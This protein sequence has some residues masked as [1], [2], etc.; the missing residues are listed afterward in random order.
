[1]TIRFPWEYVEGLSSDAYKCFKMKECEQE[2]TS[3]TKS[4][5]VP[6]PI[7]RIKTSYF[8]FKSKRPSSNL[9]YMCRYISFKKNGVNA[10]PS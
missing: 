6:F 3:K 7:S 2:V 4:G 9:F 8:N 5:H 10:M 1:M